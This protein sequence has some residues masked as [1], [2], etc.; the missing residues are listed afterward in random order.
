MLTLMM[1]QRQSLVYLLILTLILVGKKVVI[2][3]GTML[4]VS[5]L[6]NLPDPSSQVCHRSSVCELELEGFI[7]SSALLPRQGRRDVTGSPFLPL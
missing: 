2:A 7:E 3:I 4:H 1:L 5:Y 6:D